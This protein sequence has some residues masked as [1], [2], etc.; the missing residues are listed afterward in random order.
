MTTCY[1]WRGD[2]R[3]GPVANFGDLLGPLLLSHFS[4]I[5]VTWAPPEEADIIC[6]GSLLDVMPRADY[7]LIVIGAGQLHESTNTDLRY[8]NVLGLRGQLTRDRVALAGH[9]KAPVLG[10]VGLL[11]SELANVTPNRHPIGCIPHLTDKELYP[12]ELARARK[13]GYAEPHLIDIANDPI[14]VISEIG[15]C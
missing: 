10:D 11:C 1:W 3:T 12:R 15:S 4:D 14:K 2:V 9:A 5:E 13:Y 8:A 7:H 6:S